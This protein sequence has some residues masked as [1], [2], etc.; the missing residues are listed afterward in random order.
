MVVVLAIVVFDDVMVVVVVVGVVVVVS[1]SARSLLPEVL[2]SSRYDNDAGRPDTVGLSRLLECCCL[3]GCDLYRDLA[4]SL[5]MC[6]QASV[7]VYILCPLV[8]DPTVWD[9]QSPVS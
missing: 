5:L 3:G 9:R 8:V 7:H 2:R 6:R 4:T 1:D